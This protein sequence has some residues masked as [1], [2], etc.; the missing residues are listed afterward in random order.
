MHEGIYHRHFWKTSFVLFI[1][2]R[3]KDE[4]SATGVTPMTVIVTVIFILIVTVLVVFY[5][6]NQF[7]FRDKIQQRFTGIYMVCYSAL[8]KITHFETVFSKCF[9]FE[10]KSMHFECFSVFQ[11]A[12]ITLWKK[13]CAMSSQSRLDLQI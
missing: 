10:T 13:N 11:S 1:F 9:K 5:K 8:W 4:G 3:S 6:R 7:G 2:Y 12:L